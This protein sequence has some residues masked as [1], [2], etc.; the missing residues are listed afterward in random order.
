[1]IFPTVHLNGTSKSYLQEQYSDAR[2]AVSAALEAL[3]NINPNARDYYVQGDTA[4][5]QARKEHEERIASLKK[6]LEDLTQ[7]YMHVVGE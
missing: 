5:S 6:V 7:I 1:M 4:F 3:Y 2:V